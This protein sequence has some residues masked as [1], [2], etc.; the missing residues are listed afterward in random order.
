[1]R[2]CI[3]AYTSLEY[4]SIK[5]V[6]FHL[7]ATEIEQGNAFKWYD[8]KQWPCA[9]SNCPYRVLNSFFII[10]IWS[11]TVPNCDTGEIFSRSCIRARSLGFIFSLRIASSSCKLN[12]ILHLETGSISSNSLW[13]RHMVGCPT[14]EECRLFK[15]NFHRLDLCCNIHHSWLSLMLPYG[16]M[17]HH[18]YYPLSICCLKSKVA[19]H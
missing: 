7:C 4:F 6:K 13:K 10:F 16:H 3:H 11:F 12:I 14:T 15:G 8:G 9:C 17:S 18:L 5:R 19:A 2:I 1:M